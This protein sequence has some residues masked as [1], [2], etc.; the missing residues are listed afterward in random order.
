MVEKW[1]VSRMLRHLSCAERRATLVENLC[2]ILFHFGSTPSCTLIAQ[3]KI[4]HL[5]SSLL[6][7]GAS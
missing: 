1:V 3:S 5:L 6:Q 7:A 4:G 2:S